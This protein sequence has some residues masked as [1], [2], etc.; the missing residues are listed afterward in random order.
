[1]HNK[2]STYT[3]CFTIEALLEVFHKLTVNSVKLQWNE[4]FKFI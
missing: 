2:K 1:M 4:L 3:G